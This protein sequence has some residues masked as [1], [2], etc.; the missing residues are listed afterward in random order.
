MLKIYLGDLVYDTVKTNYVVPLNIAY[1]AANINV[2]FRRETDIRLFKYPKDIEKAISN[3]PP[4]I[5]A[6]SNY[7]WNSN[8]SMQFFKMA[9]RLNP[10]VITVMGGPHIRTDFESIKQFL[11]THPQLD[12]YILLEGEEPFADL[13]QEIL[14]G[15]LRPTPRGC[16]TI[17]AGEFIFNPIEYNKKPKYIDSPSPYLTGLLDEFLLNPQM[18]PLLETNRGCPNKCIYCAWGILTL[19]K[20]RL[21]SLDVVL[22]EIDY[23]ANKSAGQP[24]WIICDS[25]FGILARDIEIARK[26]RETLDRKAYHVNVLMY[27]SKNTTDRNIEITNIM[28]DRDGKIAIQSTDPVVLKNSG[29]GHI[30]MSE[31]IRYIDYY[32]SNKKTVATDILIGLPGETAESHMKTL[33]DAFK[34]GFGEIHPYNIRMLPGTK[35]ESDDFRKRYGVQT[36]FRPIFGCYG[37]YDGEIVFELEESVRATKDMSE[38][39]LNNFKIIHWLIYFAWNNG[40]FKP[41][42]N[43]GKKYGVNPFTVLSRVAASE[44]ASIKA[45]FQEMRE[46]SMSEWF[47]TSKAMVDYYKDRKNYEELVKNFVKLN[48]LYCVIICQDNQIIQLFL[49]EIVKILS[50]E[51]DKHH[52]KPDIFEAIIRLTNTLICKDIFQEEFHV[53]ENYPGEVVSCALENN[54]IEYNGDTQVEIY[55]PKEYVDL[56]NY[57]LLDGGIKDLSLQNMTKLYEMGGLK[58]FNKIRV[59]N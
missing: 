37:I 56:I 41:I 32:K 36:K 40:V 16:A 24:Y 5:L 12:Y 29:R 28:K 7:S 54:D 4:D 42:L 45:I 30:K 59:I 11:L 2:N 55:R 53:I 14:G 31:L 46:K 13:I 48:S 9:K 22:E 26:I 44:N 35:Y 33:S 21:R 57:Y 6:L 39:E 38:L 43:Y 27:G 47:N 25:N 8:L 23:I 34:I 3:N 18:I 58:V 49:N 1:L 50:E 10:K 20:I 17:I 51:I 52:Y 15:Q 19:S